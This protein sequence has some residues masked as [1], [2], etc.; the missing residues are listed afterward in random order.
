MKREPK[1][2]W[3]Y[4]RRTCRTL[5]HCEVCKQQIT[6]GQTY[7]DGGWNRRAHMT[8]VIKPPST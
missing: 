2:Y 5:H 8:C 7:Y 4:P 6:D 3:T 1:P